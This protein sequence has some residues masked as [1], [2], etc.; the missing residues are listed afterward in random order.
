MKVI[1]T[2][3]AARGGEIGHFATAFGLSVEE[4]MCRRGPHCRHRG[5]AVFVGAAAALRLRR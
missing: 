3:A 5:R 1:M 2:G 4:E